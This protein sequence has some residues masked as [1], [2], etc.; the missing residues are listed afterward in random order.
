MFTNP[1]YSNV[2]SGSHSNGLKSREK[3][4]FVNGFKYSN[5]IIE[6]SL[7]S[8]TISSHARFFLP[9]FEYNYC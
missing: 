5:M 2:G 8:A 4:G 6:Q 7:T 1:T 9:G 3:E